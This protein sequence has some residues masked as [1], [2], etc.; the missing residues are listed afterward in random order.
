MKLLTYDF[1]SRCRNC[2]RRTNFPKYSCKTCMYSLT[3]NFQLD[4]A[5]DSRYQRR[6]AKRQQIQSSDERLRK[7]YR[8]IKEKYFNGNYVPEPQYVTFSWKRGTRFNSWC[9]KT[10]KEIRMGGGYKVAFTETPEGE[11]RKRGLV[12]TM[13]H[14]ML[15]L[16]LAH[17]RKHFKEREK[18]VLALVKDEHIPE[19]YKEVS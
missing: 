1:Q 8:V 4:K 7:L 6:V 13:I 14:E 16:R 15:H 9:M 5:F 2:S 3:S 11:Q 18:E 12:F 10:T 17:H 19:I